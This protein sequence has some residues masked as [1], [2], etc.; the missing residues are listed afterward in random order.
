MRRWY[1][2]VPVWGEY[3]E[4]FVHTAL[5]TLQ[6]ASRGIN[7]DRVLLVHTDQPER[8]EQM[9]SEYLPIEARRVPAGYQ[10]FNCMSRAHAEVLD[11]AIKGD[12]VVL[13]TGD[14]VVSGNAFSACGDAFQHGRKLVACNA[15]RAVDAGGLPYR[16][17]SR[18]LAA[19]GWE[20]R[21]PITKNC[22]WPTGRAEDMPRIY[23][24]R[25]D[26]VAARLWL[27]HPLAV[28]IDGRRLPFRPTVDC[29][30]IANFSPDEIHLVTSPDEMSAL[31]LS[32]AGKRESRDDDRPPAALGLP[33][34][35]ERYAEQ[36]LVHEVYRWAVSK[37]IVVKG[38]DVD[39]G[40]EAVVDALLRAQRPETC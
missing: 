19:W 17:S 18:A 16:S 25:G 23:F 7:D 38:R 6:W 13:L 33:P 1:I 39:C 29:D 15:T 26:N 30:L 5:P 27:P 40:D 8:L 2:S 24:E 37:R 32:D 4:R 10:W 9:S 20:H 28:A 35:G 11:M 14:M 3:V 21:H 31:E 22:E 12:V 36:E 34:I